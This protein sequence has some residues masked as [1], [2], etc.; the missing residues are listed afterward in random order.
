MS[1]N[2]STCLG[3]KPP[4]APNCVPVPP[5][6]FPYDPW[7]MSKALD[8]KGYVAGPLRSWLPEVL[9]PNACRAFVENCTP[10]CRIPP[11]ASPGGWYS[12]FQLQW[13]YARLVPGRWTHQSIGLKAQRSLQRLWASS[14]RRQLRGLV[15]SNTDL[16]Q[17]SFCVMFIHCMLY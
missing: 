16:D 1:S 17:C 3:T 13:T 14:D 12:V 9:E 11:P 6:S 5:K 7:N 15:I 2:A 4:P 10:L 8:D